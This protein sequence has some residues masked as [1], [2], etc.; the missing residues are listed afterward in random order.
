MDFR[1]PNF[2]YKNSSM[3]TIQNPH[4]HRHIAYTSYLVKLNY[5]K[6]NLKN[7]ERRVIETDRCSY[8]RA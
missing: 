6:K 8:P 5:L 3:V 2:R 7:I 4:I 1:V